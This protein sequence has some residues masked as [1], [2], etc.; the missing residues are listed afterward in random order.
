VLHNYL[1]IM[2]SIG[3]V[4]LEHVLHPVMCISLKY[5]SATLLSPIS[6][7]TTKLFWHKELRIMTNVS[8]RL[9]I[10]N[11]TYL[12]FKL[13]LQNSSLNCPRYTVGCAAAACFHTEETISSTTTLLVKWFRASTHL[14]VLLYRI[15]VAP[16]P[17]GA[18]LRIIFSTTC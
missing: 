18:W 4:L 7:L 1:V 8:T 13:G 2:H 6:R 17:V 15:V 9:F 10:L 5:T 3:V 14:G 16:S 12:M 11:K